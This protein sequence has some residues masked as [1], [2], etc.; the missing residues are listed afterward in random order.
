MLKSMK[1][2]YLPLK[3]ISFVLKAA[4]VMLRDEASGRSDSKEWQFTI[5]PGAMLWWKLSMLRASA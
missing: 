4:G 3:L 2:Q 5:K 1:N